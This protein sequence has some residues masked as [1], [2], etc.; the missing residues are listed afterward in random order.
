MVNK[1]YSVGKCDINNSRG[2]KWPVDYNNNRLDM[3]RKIKDSTC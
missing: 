1:R 2:Q 3:G